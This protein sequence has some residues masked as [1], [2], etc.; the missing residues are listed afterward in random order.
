ML[1]GHPVKW[2]TSARYLGVYLESYF[3]FKCSFDVNKA[4]HYKTFKCIFW[5]NRTHCVRG[6]YICADK[7][8]MLTDLTL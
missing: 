4:K 5:K 2:I 8:L 3:T 7:K 6:G 1:C